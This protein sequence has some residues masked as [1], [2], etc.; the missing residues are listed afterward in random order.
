MLATLLIVACTEKEDEKPEYTN[1]NDYVKEYVQLWNEQNFE[2]MY[3]DYLS[4]YVKQNFSHEDYVERYNHLYDVLE[5][6]NLSINIIES[7]DFTEEELKTLQKH[8]IPISI[9]YDTLAGS[10][11][12][13]K[14]IQLNKLINEEQ[15]EEGEIQLDPRSPWLI[16]WDPSFILPNLEPGDEVRLTTLPTKR[17]EIVD[18]NGELLATQGEV[19]E[20]GVVLER[21]NEQASLSKLAKSLNISEEYIKNQYEQSWVQPQHFVPL[22]KFSLKD[23]D[24]VSQAVAIEG[25]TSRVTVDRIYPYGEVAAHLIGYIGKITSEELEELKS[26]GYSAQDRLGKRGLEELY[27][28][29]LRGQKGREIFIEKKD[30]S[31]YTVA[32]VSP[33]P[34]ENIELSVDIKV[35]EKLYNLLKED[36]GTASIINPSTGELISQVSFPAFDPNKFILGQSQEEYSALVKDESQPMINRFATTYSPGST[37]KVLST[38]IGLN[39]NQL[40]PNKTHTIKGKKWQNDGSWGDYYVTRLYDQDTE[41]D[42][43][44]A[45]KYSD[46]IYFAKLGTS[47]GQQAFEKGLQKLGFGESIPFEYPV[48]TSQISNSGKLDREVLLADT[49]YGQG[50]LLVNIVHLTSIYGGIVNNGD[51]MTPTLLSNDNQSVWLSDIVN[52]DQAQLI[53]NLLRKV[54]SEGTA[55][56]INI[57]NK[58]IAGKTGTAELKSSHEVED[59]VENG[60]FVSYDQNNPDQIIGVIIEG[61]EDSGGSSYVVNKVEQ[62]YESN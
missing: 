2:R 57:N 30:Q 60:I 32:K 5:V 51:V 41:V 15:M 27:E 25:V 8:E 38:I 44:S 7:K 3:S 20:I 47:I 52:D 40:E 37:M 19:Y 1:P 39:N 10:V 34:G 14:T 24:I 46:N 53:Q 16:E 49:A 23:Q 36:K 35:Q 61:V 54:V 21:F 4:D 26:R 59:G 22:K 9:S 50:Q 56:D 6:E 28:N 55:Q 12:Y 29:K 17:G 13:K 45:Y 62:F 31:T 11:A 42:L 43:E 18:R 58:Q 33:I 48:L